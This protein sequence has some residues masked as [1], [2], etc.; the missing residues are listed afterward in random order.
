MANVYESWH[1]KTMNENNNLIV[2]TNFSVG[3]LVAHTKYQFR[4]VVVDVIYDV[5]ASSDYNKIKTAIDYT[6]ELESQ[7][8]YKLLIDDG[9][10]LNF[11][12]EI[13]L[14]V[15]SSTNPVK[16][17]L[18][19]KYLKTNKEKGIYINSKSVH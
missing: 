12:P 15:D 9:E 7:I 14:N 11:V 13:M 3:D 6:G 2:E 10:D 18:L 1:F 16:H 8:W 4:A 17:P 5:K 19:N